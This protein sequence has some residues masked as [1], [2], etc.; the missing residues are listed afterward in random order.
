MANKGRTYELSLCKQ[1]NQ[2]YNSIVAYPAG[3]SGN[4]YGP[5]P[6]VLV[7]TDNGCHA[8]EIKKYGIDE[9]EI[10]YIQSEDLEQIVECC[11]NHTDAWLFISVSNRK[12]FA[13]R[14][15]GDIE[16]FAAN[17]DAVWSPGVT[18]AGHLRIKKPNADV[19]PS[20]RKQNALDGELLIR[21]VSKNL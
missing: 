15:E 10:R 17:I 21:E 9:G 5:S 3:Y 8:V 20:K 19:W 7:T 14:Y 12:S 11:N 1:I 16:S 2:K 18:S 6:D 4:Q 13:A